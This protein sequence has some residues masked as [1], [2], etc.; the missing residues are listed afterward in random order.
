MQSIA[1]YYVM[2]ASEVAREASATPR[3]AHAPR[4]TS[5]IAALLASIG[6]P[7]R[8]AAVAAA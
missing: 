1:A 7:V 3:Y 5:R 4:R 8:R 2:V 6:R